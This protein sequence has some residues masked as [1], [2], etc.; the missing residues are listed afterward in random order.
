MRKKYNR[1]RMFWI[2]FVLSLLWMGVIFFFSAQPAVESS[3]LSTNT[4]DW[5]LSSRSSKNSVLQYLIVL[6][7]QF[8]QKG[9]LEFLVRK[10]AHAA[11]YGILAIF[12]GMTI[13]F[14]EQWNSR[15]QQ[16]TV[17]LC[18]LYACTDE[19]HQL[20]V[21]GRA[22]QV[23]DVIIDTIGAICAVFL[24]WLFFLVLK[25]WRPQAGSC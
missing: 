11:E 1:K 17:G 7:R 22:G 8:D 19:F 24:V 16:K 6:L 25:K 10:L 12:L 3:K 18:V 2:F 15:W 4:V 9:I 20:F 21:P 13:Y 23:Q 14:S 5:L